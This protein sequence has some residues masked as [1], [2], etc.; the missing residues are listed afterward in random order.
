[1]VVNAAAAPLFALVARM[2]EDPACEDESLL[3]RAQRGERRAFDQLYQRHVNAV[4]GRLTRLVGPSSELEDLVQRTFIELYRALPSFRG[5]APLGAFIHGIAVRVGYDYLRK[6]ARS[7]QSHWDEAA[8]LDL[9]APGS[10][11]EAAAHERQEL[12]LA[13]G[14]LDRLKPKKRVA[15]V[16]H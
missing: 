2:G 12:K 15:F 7:R 9:V 6:R 4:Y 11:P 3:E 1:M 10:S 5:E 14:R 13:F 8:V 16:L